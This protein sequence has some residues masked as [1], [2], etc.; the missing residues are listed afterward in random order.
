MKNDTQFIYEQP[1]AGWLTARKKKGILGI[2]PIERVH[3]VYKG[4]KPL[5]KI[6]LLLAIY[7]VKSRLISPNASP[8]HY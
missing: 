5:D 2:S 1:R 4:G 6:V 3:D 7:Y 8:W